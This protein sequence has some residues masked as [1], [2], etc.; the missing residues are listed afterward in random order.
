MPANP[1]ALSF[2]GIAKEVTAGTFVPAVDYLP[3]T[4]MDPK[5]MT[6][7]LP[8]G[9]WRGSMAET[10][11]KVAGPVWSELS[12]GGYVYPDTI[13]Y[14]L[15]GILGVDTLSGTAAPY[16][17]TLTL[18]NTADGQPT[19]QSFNDFNSVENRG[20]TSVKWKDVTVSWDGEKYLTW[21][22]NAAGFQS[23]TQTKPS[24]S[25]STIPG[26]PGWLSTVTIGGVS[27]LNMI[28]TEI[29]FK[30]STE[31]IHTA[32]GT[33]APYEIF[34]GPLA[35]T[36]KTVIVADANTQLAAYLAQAGGGTKS[37]LLFDFNQG[38]AGTAVEVKFQLSSVNFDLVVPTRGKTFVE[39]EITWDALAN[40]TDASGGLAPCQV[41]L[42]N[43]KA[44]AVYV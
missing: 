8:D 9:A 43:A 39:Y 6:L 44:T 33:Q 27:A 18:K 20:Y 16:S 7:W 12:C 22:G 4:K 17:H 34:A 21:D 15:A 13:G 11:G 1:T 24:Q 36:G 41:L 37:S 42:K 32:D 40:T 26:L 23:A 2:I 35:V 31:P 3:L 10:Y 14:P 29:A 30:R 38:T 25:F 19:T 5:D 28:S